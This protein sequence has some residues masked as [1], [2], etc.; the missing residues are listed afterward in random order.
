MKMFFCYCPGDSAIGYFRAAKPGAARYQA[1]K[2]YANV[3]CDISVGEMLTSTRAIRCPVLDDVAQ[4]INLIDDGEPAILAARGLA[5]G[6]D[7]ERQYAA[8]PRTPEQ[9]QKDRAHDEY[10]DSLC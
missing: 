5:H 9:Y 7:D 4:D 3:F 8:N 10:I 1:A 6:E 2:I